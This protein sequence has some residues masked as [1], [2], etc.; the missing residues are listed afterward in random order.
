MIDEDLRR[1]LEKLT[2]DKPVIKEKG[3]EEPEVA[4][5]RRNEEG[6]GEDS[7]KGKSDGKE[8][9]QSLVDKIPDNILERTRVRKRKV[10]SK[11][12]AK[13]LGQGQE[14]GGVAHSGRRC[15]R[16]KIVRGV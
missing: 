10:A 8:V 9:V 3:K 14:S 1:L 5:L 2:N 11:E 16:R 15:W 7:L 13:H 4:I 6:G 12:E